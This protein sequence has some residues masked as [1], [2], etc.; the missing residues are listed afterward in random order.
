MKKILSIIL[1]VT[2][3]FSLSIAAFA[4]DTT[5]LS[6]L[7]SIVASLKKEGVNIQEALKGL[8]TADLQKAF[9]TIIEGMNKEDL[10]KTLQAAI[11]KVDNEDLQDILTKALKAAGEVKLEDIKDT[12]KI[13]GV[14]DDVLLQVQDKTGIDV[15]TL[16]DKLADSEI[17]NVFAKMYIPAVPTTAA[18]TT[19]APIPQTGSAVGGIAIFATLSL[20]AAAAFVCTKKK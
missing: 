3:A 16:K 1:A 10:Q 7:D 18:A 15:Q 6:T 14:V 20:A 11:E 19:A 17:F 9:T 4:A 5:T 12:D 8:S 2:M 13:A